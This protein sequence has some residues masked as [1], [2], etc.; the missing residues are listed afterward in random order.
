MLS[1]LKMLVG[2][3]CEAIWSR[4]LFIGSFVTDSLSLLAIGLFICSLCFLV[5]SREIV[6][7]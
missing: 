2:F 5:Q 6:L 7:F 4:T 1:H 3:T